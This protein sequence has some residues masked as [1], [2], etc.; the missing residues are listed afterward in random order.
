MVL[1]PS[2]TVSSSSMTFTTCWAGVRLFMTSSDSA[3][4]R[5]RV[6]EV[7]GDLDGDVGLEQGGADLGQG[8]V[9][10]L[11]VELAPAA[12]L[13]EDAVEAVAQSVEHKV[14]ALRHR[15]RDAA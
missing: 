7:V 3:R 15:G 2:V 13:L 1:A 14:R 12:E 4:A 9:H 8:V 6:E 10:L 11:G 5:T